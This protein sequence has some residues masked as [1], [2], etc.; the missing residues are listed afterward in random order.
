MSELPPDKPK[1]TIDTAVAGDGF[2]F[3]GQGW[4][5]YVVDAMN[6]IA[7]LQTI[8]RLKASLSA[9]AQ[10]PG[11]SLELRAALINYDAIISRG[12]W[13]LDPEWDFV[14]RRADYRLI[15]E[16]LSKLP[17]LIVNPPKG[18]TP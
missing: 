14:M 17:T 5:H 3:D 18:W 6:H 7:L 2:L 16:V 8:D 12:D 4:H 1:R 15:R 10:Q 11:I 9:S 13:D